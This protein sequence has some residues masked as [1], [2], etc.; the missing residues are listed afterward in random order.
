MTAR[1]GKPTV[2]LIFAWP[3]VQGDQPMPVVNR[4]R[5]GPNNA[6][7][8]RQKAGFRTASMGSTIVPSR[9][10]QAIK[11]NRS[12]LGIRKS[13]PESLGTGKSKRQREG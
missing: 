5:Y 11:D 8:L 7:V 4:C 10:L 3:L 1:R 13:T 6:L 2:L 12:T 9:V